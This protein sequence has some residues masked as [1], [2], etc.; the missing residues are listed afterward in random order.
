MKCSRC[1]IKIKRLCSFTQIPQYAHTGDSGAD[2]HAIEDCLLQPFERKAIPTGLCVEIPD[3]FELQV[4]PKSGL[5]LDSGI[6]VL[7]TPGTIDSTYR[8]EIK[9]ILINLSSEIYQIKK[10]QKIA[11]VV[12][13]PVIQ[14]EF[15]EVE[16]LSESK[17]G[18]G[19]F[20]STTIF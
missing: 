9:V 4:R 6:T 16:E 8:G 7:N 19:G 14:A 17:R 13:S 10:G 20:G 11:Q 15:R 2:L 5:A 12:V 3:G 18:T 1:L